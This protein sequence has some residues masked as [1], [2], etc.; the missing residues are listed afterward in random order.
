VIGRQVKEV[1]TKDDVGL[2][3]GYTARFA[4]LLM[5]ELTMHG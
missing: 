1:N 5:W 4:K 2:K 3:G